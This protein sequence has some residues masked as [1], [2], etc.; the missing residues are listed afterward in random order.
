MND[1]KSRVSYLQGLAK[2]L[3]LA[4]E[5]NEGRLLQGILDV[6]EDIAGE[7]SGMKT[8]FEQLEEYVDAMDEDLADVEEEYF[9]DVE[10]EGEYAEFKCPSCG[11]KITMDDDYDTGEDG[12]VK[13]ICPKCGETIFEEDY[14]V[15]EDEAPLMAH[16]YHHGHPYGE[17]D[18]LPKE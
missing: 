4:D 8:S 9:G 1:V 16:R 11:S 5:S 2:G 3:N 7:I 15:D 12:Q 13:L 18:R 10:T 17:E 14:T 6:L